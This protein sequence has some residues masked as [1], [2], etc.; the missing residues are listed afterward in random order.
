MKKVFFVLGVLLSLGLFSACSSDDGMGDVYEGQT[1][2]G[3]SENVDEE[4]E[5]LQGTN[6][7]LVDFQLQNEDGIE[8]YEFNE[9]DNI[10]F[11]LEIKN[12]SDEDAYVR[13]FTEI[14]GFD[15]F[16]V[17]SQYGAIIGTPW[18]EILSNSRGRDFIPAHGSAIFVCPWFDIPALY[19]NGHEHYYSNM[20]YKKDE[21][22]PLPKG[23]YYS[24]F[25]VKLNDKT[26]ICNRNFMIK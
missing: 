5:M 3:N 10:I 4:G 14:I 20:Y 21:K 17:Y 7:D 9:G 23:E 13:P 18:D 24:R 11:K 2:I 8:C 6:D 22:L 25:D 12:E 19:C 16:R 1:P 26:I 15:A